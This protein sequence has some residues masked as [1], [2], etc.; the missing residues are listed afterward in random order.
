MI[1]LLNGSK[2]LIS[3]KLEYLI[4]TELPVDAYLP[5]N[6]RPSL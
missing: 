2:L 6:Y 5:Q 4:Y 1:L 3:S